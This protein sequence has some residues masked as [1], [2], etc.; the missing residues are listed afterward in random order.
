MAYVGVTTRA[1]KCAICKK[2]IP[3]GTFVYCDSTKNQGSHL[4]E[5]PCYDRLRASRDKQPPRGREAK[6]SEPLDPPF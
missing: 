3:K 5:V 1:G 6:S 2:S 4:A